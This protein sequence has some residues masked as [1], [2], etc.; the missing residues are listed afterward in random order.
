[1]L[2]LDQ[3]RR[4]YSG[5]NISERN[6]VREY[7][8]YKMLELIFDSP[9]AAKLNFIGGTAIRIIY[10]SD[11]F[12]EDLDF[13]NFGLAREEFVGLTDLL[14][15]ELIREGFKVEVRRVFQESFRC[16]FKFVELLYDFG[17]SGHR[18]ERLVIQLDTTGQDFPVEVKHRIVNKFGVFSEVRVN[19]ADILLAQKFTA[20]LGRKRMVGR[21]LYDVVYLSSL[22]GVNM[23]YLRQKAGID[24][25]E[26]LV[27]EV[28]QR[29]AGCDLD[30]LVQDVTPF[31]SD[32]RRLKVVR[33]F[34]RWLEE[35]GK[36][37]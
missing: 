13:D 22:S 30:S 26:E 1:M 25:M 2:S 31:V 32:E 27:A 6:T 9:M 33:N 23:A 24:G 28:G 21:D 5:A 11:R 37:A 8:Q 17:I 10:G 12:S 14:R 4:F 20:I 18:Q 34:P 19:P 29:V 15:R 36:K 16:Y 3:I 35:W 7:L